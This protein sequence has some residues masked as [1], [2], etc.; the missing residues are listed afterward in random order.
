MAQK[1]Y[2]AQSLSIAPE[3]IVAG[4]PMGQARHK[5]RPDGVLAIYLE[6]IPEITK[7]GLQKR[8][9]RETRMV[10]K[11]QR[12]VALDAAAYAATLWLLTDV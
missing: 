12:S 5:I 9:S 6:F 10:R 8:K 1:I 2:W 11:K 4:Q 3:L 7:S